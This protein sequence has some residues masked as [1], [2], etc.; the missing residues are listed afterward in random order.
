MKSYSEPCASPCLGH[1][2]HGDLPTRAAAGVAYWGGLEITGTQLGPRGR[3]RRQ[4]GRKVP[5]IRLTLDPRDCGATGG[6]RSGP[7][8]ILMVPH[9]ASLSLKVQAAPVEGK[10]L[11]W[12]YRQS[13]PLL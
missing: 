8:P 4:G 1:D 10:G 7:P 3:Q 9:A 11:P 2:G 13:V 6:S 5:G 12:R